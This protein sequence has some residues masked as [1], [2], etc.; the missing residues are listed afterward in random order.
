[1]EIILPKISLSLSKM[2]T[3]VLNL[4]NSLFPSLKR[5]LQLEELSNKEQKLI[6]I[7]DF[8]AIEKNITVVSITNT[9][10]HREEI[11][12]AF[13][14]KSVYNI[15]TTRDLIDRLH[16]DRTLR[17]LCGWRYKNDIPSESKFS[18]VFKE[19]S[20]LKI[21]QKTHEQFVK[22]YLGYLGTFG[23]NATKKFKDS[24]SFISQVPF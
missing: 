2:W 24:L 19:L 12:R 23:K 5:E 6:K 11:A 20:A 4:E 7:L 21:A 9:P 15:Q 16:S 3:K 22:E 1:M 8:A 14:A 10:K 17:I 18:R 13:I